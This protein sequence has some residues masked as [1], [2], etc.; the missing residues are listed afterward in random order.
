MRATQQNQNAA[1]IMGIKVE[2]VFSFTWGMS[3]LIGAVA[4]M[5]F[6]ARPVLAPELHDGALHARCLPP[7]CSAG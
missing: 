3:S 7:P 6:A 4:A 5:F 2:R 1:K